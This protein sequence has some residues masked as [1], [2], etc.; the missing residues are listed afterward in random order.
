MDWLTKILK[1]LRLDIV[2]APTYK[3]AHPTTQRFITH[4]RPEYEIQCFTYP[5]PPSPIPNPQAMFPP[6]KPKPTESQPGGNSYPPRNANP[7][8]PTTTQRFQSMP[9]TGGKTN[10]DAANQQQ[11]QAFHEAEKVV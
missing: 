5:C 8:P 7:L 6:P 1:L 10:E 2:P 11:D 9:T 3:E 4:P